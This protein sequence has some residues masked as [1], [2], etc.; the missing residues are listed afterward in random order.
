MEEKRRE[1]IKKEYITEYVAYDGTVFTCKEE[2]KKYEGSAEA[3]LYTKYKPLVICRKSECE[4]Y[5]TG[6]EEYEIDIIKI[7]DI[8]DIDILMQL[9]YIHNNY[10]S[11]RSEEK[12][13][14][15]KTKL[16]TYFNNGDI[17]FVG[18]GCGYDKY[19]Q[20]CFINSLQEV[21]NHITKTCTEHEAN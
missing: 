16:T 18:R 21:I 3:V 5:D 4:I 9:Y 11:A 7:N 15:I 12:M 17:I 14:E 6:S 2:C 1:I 20:F 13:Q 19:D 10:P 8:K